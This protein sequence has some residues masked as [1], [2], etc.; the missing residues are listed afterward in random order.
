MKRLPRGFR[1][2][3][4]DN[5]ACPHRDVTCCD[6]CAAKHLEIV[7]VYG[8]HFWVP[9]QGERVELQALKLLHNAA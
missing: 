9:D 4:T 8:Q 3:H 5:L 6:E 1:R 7:E 2:G